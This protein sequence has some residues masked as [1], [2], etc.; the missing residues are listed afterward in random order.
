MAK[1]TYEE[2]MAKTPEFL[3]PVVKRYG[4]TLIAWTAEELWA[5]IERM[6]SGDT[7]GAW[8]QLVNGLDDT[9]LAWKNVLLKVQVANVANAAHMDMQKEAILMT[10]KGLLMVVSV[11]VGF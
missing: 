6:I 1:L 5:W 9:E 4:K 11:M 8:Q 2:L 3:Q 10:L 7:A